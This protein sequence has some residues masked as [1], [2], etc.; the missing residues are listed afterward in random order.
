VEPEY[1]QLTIRQAHNAAM[2][3]KFKHASQTPDCD[4]GVTSV[5]IG[6]L[7]L[8]DKFSKG[9]IQQ[10]LYTKNG[11]RSTAQVSGLFGQQKHSD[12]VNRIWLHECR[13]ITKVLVNPSCTFIV[14][15]AARQKNNLFCHDCSRLR[16]RH[17]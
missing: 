1:R 16:N 2:Y 7:Q 9:D 5:P 15:S 17:K 4:Q 3:T 11:V 8:L 12:L 13:N 10:N 6:K 14:L